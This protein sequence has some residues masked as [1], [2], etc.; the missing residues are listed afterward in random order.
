MLDIYLHVTFSESNTSTSVNSIN[1]TIQDTYLSMNTS[2]NMDIPSNR[3]SLHDF[4]VELVRQIGSDINS[5]SQLFKFRSTCRYARDAINE[6]DIC[7]K[8]TKFHMKCLAEPYRRQRN[9]RKYDIFK[10]IDRMVTIIEHR[11]D[12]PFIGEEDDEWDWMASMN[13]SCYGDNRTPLF[14]VMPVPYLIHAIAGGKDIAEINRCISAYQKVF[15]AGLHGEWSWRAMAPNFIYTTSYF[16]DRNTIRQDISD[17]KHFIRSIIL[18]DVSSPMVVAVAKG[19][20]DVVQALVK[21]GVNMRGRDDRAPFKCHFTLSSVPDHIEN[22][23]IID[24][25][26]NDNAFRIACSNKR[27][28][29]ALYMISNGLEVRWADIL[30]AIEFGCFE[31]FETLLDHPVFNTHHRLSIITHALHWAGDNKIA[32]YTMIDRLLKLV[33][34]PYFDKI[35]WLSSKIRDGTLGGI[36]KG[37]LTYLFN[38]WMKS[39]HPVAG[40]REIGLDACS[41]AKHLDIVKVMFL[42][43]SIISDLLTEQEGAQKD[44]IKTSILHGCYEAV[45]FYSSVRP[46][47]TLKMAIRQES[48]YGSK[49][50]P[51]PMVDFILDNCSVSP[52]PDLF[53]GQLK[54][55]LHFALATETPCKYRILRSLLLRGADYTNVPR[56]LK[57]KLYKEHDDIWLRVEPN[58]PLETPPDLSIFE[59]FPEIPSIEK[60]NNRS[61]AMA[62]LIMGKEYLDEKRKERDLN[63]G[64]GRSYTI[65]NGYLTGGDSEPD[66]AEEEEEE[67]EYLIDIQLQ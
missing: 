6:F 44:M 8:D 41:K 3:M 58:P 14:P 12:Q 54:N 17:W 25:W 36:P 13:T 60:Y 42:Q 57:D 20:L 30:A 62:Y 47:L 63:G 48:L 24:G 7:T 4:P 18:D 52:T 46:A 50:R 45:R 11:I 21:C 23:M 61:Y 56:K 35:L 27:E 22:Q 29:V 37:Q 34:E 10:R 51:V 16:Y 26:R 31:V 67:E 19:R 55:P 53:D 9:H 28:D 1:S 43:P 15:P 59:E 39:K 33:T 49:S 2:S 38:M 40:A 32:D 64:T 66:E 5:M 65:F